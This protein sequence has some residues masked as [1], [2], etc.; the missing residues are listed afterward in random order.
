MGSRTKRNVPLTARGQPED[1]TTIILTSRYN[2]EVELR[3]LR[4]I[5]TRVSP[6]KV[7]ELF[8]DSKSGII[9][10]RMRYELNGLPE[11]LSDCAVR[12]WLE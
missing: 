5:A 7:R 10:L 4:E 12:V 3:R 8:Y 6:Q 1:E 11:P 9:F 2:R